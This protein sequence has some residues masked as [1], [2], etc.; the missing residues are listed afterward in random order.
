LNMTILNLLDEVR[1][2]NRNAI[3]LRSAECVSSR[4][5]LAGSSAGQQPCVAALLCS[6]IVIIAQ[7]CRRCEG[8]WTTVPGCLLVCV[9]GA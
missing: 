3:Q 9:C 2:G 5:C 8:G 4:D 7:I 1:I 6:K